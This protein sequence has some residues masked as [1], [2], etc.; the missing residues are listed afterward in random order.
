MGMRGVRR[1]TCPGMRRLGRCCAGG[2]LKSFGHV[3]KA[4]DLIEI[5]VSVEWSTLSTHRFVATGIGKHPRGKD[6][7]L[8]IRGD[9]LHD[10][11]ASPKNSRR[12]RRGQVRGD[13]AVSVQPELLGSRVLSESAVL[14][15]KVT[16]VDDVG[17]S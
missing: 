7:R 2:C 3:L 8:L 10:E 11:V 5:F 12:G 15:F 4:Q 6:A 13:E 1:Q 16:P 17:L 9:A 14:R